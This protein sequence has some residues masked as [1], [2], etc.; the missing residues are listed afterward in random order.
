MSDKESI[1]ISIEQKQEMIALGDS[2]QRLAKNRDWKKLVDTAFFEQESVRLV[3]L[4]A[5]PGMQDEVSQKEIHNQ[6][7]GIAYFRQFLGR[8]EMFAAQARV[9]LP[10]DEAT[11]VEI[12]EEEIQ[13]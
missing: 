9:A 8:T 2:I 5:H 10:E 6:M 3:S 12:L 4:L 1:R 11:E 7:V 13:E